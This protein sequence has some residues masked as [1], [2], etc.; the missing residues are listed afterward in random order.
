MDQ[1]YYCVTTHATPIVNYLTRLAEDPHDV[2]PAQSE[3]G[4]WHQEERF[5]FDR[6]SAPELVGEENPVLKDD[7]IYL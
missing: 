1:L 3:K 2:H 7:C 6:Y 5:I 4:W